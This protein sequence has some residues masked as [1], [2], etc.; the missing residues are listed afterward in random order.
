MIQVLNYF[1]AVQKR[2]AFD[3]REFFTRE[4]ALG[5]QKVEEAA[6]G[7][8]FGKDEHGNLKAKKGGSAGPGGIN[9]N[10][11][12]RE[13]DDGKSTRISPDGEQYVD[14]ISLKGYKYNKS[15]NPQLSST[16][17]CVP[18]FHSTFG[19]PSLYEE[20][21][22]ELE[23]RD[24]DQAYWRS[25]ARP[26]LSV[27][28]RLIFKQRLEASPED[29]EIA[30]LD[31]HGI[32]VV[33]EEAINDL[34]QLEE[35]MIKIGSYFLNK[36]ELAQHTGGS[37]QPSTMLDRGEVALHLLQHEL[38]LQLTKIALVESLL[39]AYEHT[40]DPLESVRL[41]Q[42][43]ADCMSLRPRVNLE[44]TYFTDSYRSE[45]DA[46]RQR[47]ELYQEVLSLQR[48]T[49]REENEE[50]RKFQ[51]LK[52]RKLMDFAQGKWAYE[53]EPRRVERVGAK[54]E[55]Q[56]GQDHEQIRSTK[57]A[58]QLKDVQRQLALKEIAERHITEFAG[59]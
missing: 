59:D 13:L 15:F 43:I 52:M 1:R 37:D 4:R 55:Q 41:L 16:C 7:P 20:V 29:C 46:L 48:R 19:R 2:L 51:E 21:S 31:E 9:A 49:E 47:T 45:I 33:Y 54:E 27:K 36:A 5:G 57:R 6:I 38:E 11:L 22:E 56:R 23:R 42:T 26:L 39:E 32:R 58:Q 8:Q 30:V 40:C 17:P 12:G 25:E 14:P 28:D 18:R 24:L 50:V 35:E 3:V 10:R 34:L 44:A 53:H